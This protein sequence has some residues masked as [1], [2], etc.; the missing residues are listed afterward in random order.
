MIDDCVFCDAD[1]PRRLSCSVFLCCRPSTSSRRH[2]LELRRHI[3]TKLYIQMNFEILFTVTKNLNQ[4][5]VKLSN[6]NRNLQ[7]K[8]FVQLLLEFPSYRYTNFRIA[9]YS[10]PELTGIWSLPLITV[11]RGK[12]SNNF[13]NGSRWKDDSWLVNV[14]T[15]LL[16]PGVKINLLSIVDRR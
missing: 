13:M 6:C 4:S 1:R 10:Y 15:C 8:N 7:Q 11:F 12:Y 3:V 5:E 2:E 16:Q 9:R 14:L